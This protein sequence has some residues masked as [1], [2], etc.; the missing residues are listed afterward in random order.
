MFLGHFGVGFGAKTLQ[1]HVSLGALFLA[2]QLADLAWSILLLGIER[3]RIVPHFTATNAF[4][5][6]SYPF[7]H[8]AGTAVSYRCAR[9]A[10]DAAHQL[11]RW[12]A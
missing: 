2:A 6:V 11:T 7:T 4:D 10:A 9:P 3:V 12:P 5:F 1:P 8:S